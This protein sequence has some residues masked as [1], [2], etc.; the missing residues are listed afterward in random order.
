MPQKIKTHF[1]QWET[2]PN[3][4]LIISTLIKEGILPESTSEANRMLYA[5]DII[6][7]IEDFVSTINPNSKIKLTVSIKDFHYDE[8]NN[9]FERYF[10]INEKTIEL[11]WPDQSKILMHTLRRKFQ[12]ERIIE[13][14]LDDN[15]HTWRSMSLSS[16]WESL[17]SWIKDADKLTS[18]LRNLRMISP[19]DVESVKSRLKWIDLEE[20]NKNL[21]KILQVWGE[22]SVDIALNKKDFLRA[23]ISR[24]DLFKN[25]IQKEDLILKFDKRKDKK[26]IQSYRYI[27]TSVILFLIVLILNWVTFFSHLNNDS[28]LDFNKFIEVFLGQNIYLFT[29][30]ILILFLAFY[31]LSLFKSYLKIIELYDSHILLIEADFFYKNDEQ[32]Q[33]ID[34]KSALFNMRKENTQKIHNLPEKTFDLLNGKESLRENPSSIKILEE[35]ITIVKKVIN[36]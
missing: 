29:V 14:I 5:N 6:K 15:L 18:I 9:L 34:N 26:T 12:I 36:K 11:I 1:Q 17:L 35:I 22:I 16:R 2:I 27:W 13:R 4:E 30:E 32:F 31:F 23:F 7:I 33:D 24:I 21:D 20:I 28:K 19:K 8:E 3:I 25:L 10:R